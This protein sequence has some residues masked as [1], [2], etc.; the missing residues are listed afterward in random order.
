MLVV[1]FETT[2]IRQHCID[3]KEVHTDPDLLFVFC[4]IKSY[5]SFFKVHFY[6]IDNKHEQ[7]FP[8]PTA[9]VQ[10]PIPEHIFLQ[11][12]AI[13]ANVQIWDV[14]QFDAKL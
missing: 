6:T 7:T 4:E 12:A 3:V 9:H 14:R 2:F 5:A 8:L 11:G 1:L 10:L 13:Q